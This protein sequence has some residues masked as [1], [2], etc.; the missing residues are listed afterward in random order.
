MRGSHSG[1]DPHECVRK[2]IALVARD[3][4]RKRVVVQVFH[5]DGNCR[6]FGFV[7]ALRREDI[8]AAAV[9]R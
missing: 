2:T 4:R 8:G 9:L 6:Q 7:N 1:A 5:G 3:R